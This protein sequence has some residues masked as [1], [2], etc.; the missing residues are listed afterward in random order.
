MRK[1]YA[2]QFLNAEGNVAVGGQSHSRDRRSSSASPFTGAAGGGGGG[3]GGT[4][5]YDTN[6]YDRGAYVETSRV[7]L[8]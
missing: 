1:R 6:D 2:D 4:E 8:E 5:G 3:G 7:G